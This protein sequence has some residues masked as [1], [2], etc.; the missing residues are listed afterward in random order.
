MKIVL[1]LC[2]GLFYLNSWAYAAEQNGSRH[3][4]QLDWSGDRILA[5]V[6]VPS[7]EQ[8][9]GEVQLLQRGDLLVVQTLLS[10]RILK[11]VIA[12]IDAKEQANWPETRD[13]HLDSLRYRDELF[14]ATEKSWKAFR[15]RSDRSETRQTLAIEFILAAETSLIALSVPTLRGDYG[16][17]QLIDKQP[18]KSWR[19]NGD[20]VRTNLFKI[21]EDSFRLDETA[22]AERL[23]T[24][25][26]RP[27][28]AAGH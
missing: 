3:A 4:E 5:R 6:I 25:W 12:A 24:L 16:H 28:P 9:Q 19:V 7:I 18:V 10:S 22:T 21:V 20:Y 14:R 1:I 11:R 26:P 23:K 13:G 17:L 2:M 27:E 15:Q 8:P